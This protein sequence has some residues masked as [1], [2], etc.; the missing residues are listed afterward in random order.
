MAEQ[1]DRDTI[2]SMDRYSGMILLARLFFLGVFLTAVLSGLMF[3]VRRVGWVD[4]LQYQDYLDAFTQGSLRGSE[5]LRSFTAQLQQGNEWMVA[6]YA[7]D[8][9]VL[10]FLGV[11]L[12][13]W[14]KWGRERLRIHWLILLYAIFILLSAAYYGIRLASF[15]TLDGLRNFSFLWIALA[16]FWASRHVF[17]QS[18]ARWVLFLL[19]IQ[20]M[21]MPVELIRG[22]HFFGDGFLK[23]DFANR[24][25]GTFLQPDILGIA[26]VLLFS[27][28]CS[29]SDAGMTGLLFAATCAAVL[30]LL[31]GSAV[32]LTLLV[33]FV[34]LHPLNFSDNM[35]LRQ[36]VELG[37]LLFLTLV[38]FLPQF[39]GF[40][41]V[42]NPLWDRI[43]WFSNYLATDLL[44]REMLFGRGLGAG[45]PDILSGADAV[46][47]S[48]SWLFILIWQ[49]GIVGAAFFYAIMLWGMIQDQRARV[50]YVLIMTASLAT[51]VVEIFPVNLILGLLL[52]NTF[53]RFRSAALRRKTAPIK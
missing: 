22:L 6:K 49:T 11:S 5:L 38:A 15:T 31:S 16:G 19:V 45:V 52:A 42:L 37:L 44:N 46:S 39:H 26:A 25:V 18:L 4:P 30:V 14:R 51:N 1:N 33:L 47:L 32:A 7:G 2:A 20:C 8:L 9:L 10:L 36:L 34:I 13:I 41:N 27:F 28:W 35:D 12:I 53:T 23:N 50:F 21:L 48:K 40:Q 17:L 3:W 24:M 43:I 29:I